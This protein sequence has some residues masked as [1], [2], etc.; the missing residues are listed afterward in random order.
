MTMATM[1]LRLRSTARR[2]R[3][4]AACASLALLAACGGGDAVDP[5]AGEGGAGGGGGG[6]GSGNIVG[7][8]LVPSRL[9]LAIGAAAGLRALG[10]GA[11]TTWMSSDATVATVDPAGRVVA[12]SKGKAVITATSGSDVATSTLTVYRT[13]GA[14]PDPTGDALIDAALAKHLIDAETAL[15][16]RV[17]ALFGDERLPAAYEGAPSSAP[18]HLLLRELMTTIGTLSPA[19][20]SVLRPFLLPP[21]YIDSWFAQ[22]LGLGATAQTASTHSMQAQRTTRLATP[23]CAVG[24][25]PTLYAKV[26]TAHFNVYYTVFGGAFFATENA[27]SAAAAAL[28]A[29]LIEEVYDAEVK[30]IDPLELLD[31]SLEDCNGGDKKY[32]I[33]YG[34]FGLSVLASCG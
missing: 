10:G 3:R 11:T 8:A 14:S 9:G 7:L 13:D 18:Q 25:A 32:D 24:I 23:N 27:Q 33:Y 5:A 34:P 12:L 1:D 19:A 2:V 21:I 17:F 22:R 15:V 26:S 20:Q 31:D 28:V 16:Y 4:L 29:S 30:L 6:V